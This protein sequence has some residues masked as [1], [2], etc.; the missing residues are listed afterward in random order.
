LTLSIFPPAFKRNTWK[1]HWERR[2]AKGKEK[3][4]NSDRYATL[5]LGKIHLSRYGKGR[6]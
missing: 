6:I 2:R 3:C 4:T 5:W 1:Q